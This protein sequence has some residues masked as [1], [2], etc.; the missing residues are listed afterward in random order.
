MQLN[1]TNRIGCL[2]QEKGCDV[3]DCLINTQTQWFW[4]LMVLILYK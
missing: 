3:S 2:T 1:T 4:G